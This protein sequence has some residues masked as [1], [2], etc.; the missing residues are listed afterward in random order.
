MPELVERLD[1]LQR[2][3]RALGVPLAVVYKFFDDQGNY[4][5]A[6]LTYY[7]FVAIFP[8]LLTASSV[9]GFLLQGDPELRMSLLDSALSQFPIVGTQLGRPEGLQGSTSAVVVGSLAALYGIVGLG[10]AG[11]NAVNVTWAVPRNSRLNPV[12][13]RLRSVV[14]M[15]LAGLTVL[16]VTA[17]SSLA[18]YVDVFGAQSDAWLDLLIRLLSIAVTAAALTVMMGLATAEQHRF[19]TV[20]PGATWIAVLWH[21]LQ[22]LGGLYVER[23]VSRVS[24]MN[25]LF[26]LVLGLVALIYVAAVIGVLGMEIN[27][28]LS[29]GLYPR[30]LLTPFTDDVSL[31]PA[32]RRAYT[33]YARA[34]R[35]KGFE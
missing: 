24:E 12:V 30:A 27:V 16:A 6:T 22:T 33:A 31:T 15:V 14:V 4:L 7:A 8:I 3:R 5:A 23:V 2:R 1:A 18:G 21:L 9:L 11:Q 10:Q 29:K 19:L 17:L 25:A 32:D 20:L 13:S 26:A 34:Q 35:H 28:V